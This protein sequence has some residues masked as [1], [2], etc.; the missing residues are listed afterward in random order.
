VMTLR[1]AWISVEELDCRLHDVCNPKPDL[2]TQAHKSES[3]W[4]LIQKL[5]SPL[6]L[7][8][9]WNSLPTSSN[10]D[11]ENEEERESLMR[12]RQGGTE[13]RGSLRR[14]RRKLTI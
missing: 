3:A 13:G 12:W 11:E 5:D 8:R 7:T 9:R 10:D 4:T 6:L 14:N 1:W 2:S